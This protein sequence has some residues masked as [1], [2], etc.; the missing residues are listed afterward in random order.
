MVFSIPG[1]GE[2]DIDTI[3]LDLNG[4]LAIDGK[5]ID[6]VKERIEALRALALRLFLFTGDT[7]G[8]AAEIAR[9]LQLEVRVTKSALAK[10]EE[11][12]KLGADTAAAIGNGRIDAK[13]FEVV[14]LRILTLQAEGVHRETLLNS[15]IIVPTIND[16]LDLFLKPQRLIATM[17]T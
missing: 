6:G 3:I 4:T 5:V 9:E 11:A 10:A 8:N 7:H 12:V 16:A 2:L 13:L 14:R 1:Q 17:R 15:D